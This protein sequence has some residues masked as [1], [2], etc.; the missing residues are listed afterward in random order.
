VADRVSSPP[1]PPEER[2]SSVGTEVGGAG[3]A[4]AR[5]A[6][7]LVLGQ[8]GTTTLSIVLNAA[9][10]RALGAA[11]FGM[12]FLVT[13]MAV[14]AYVFVDWGQSSYIIRDLARRP[15]R[16]GD[17]LATS[18]ALRVI[19]A[20]LVCGPV[21]VVA[22][23]LQYDARTRYLSTL[24]IA[25]MLPT[26]L[27]QC[28]TV[29]FRSQERME[30]DALV[31]VLA[32]AATLTLTLVAIAQ[33]GRLRAA[34][35]AQGL[36]GIVALA[37]AAVLLRRLGLPRLR[38]SRRTAY[39]LLV[40]GT[41]FAAIILTI[42]AQSYLDAVV[43]SKLAP[44]QVLGWYGAA[45]NI[46]NTLITPATIIASAA[47]PRLARASPSASAF[48]TEVRAALRPLLGLGA[49][50]AVGTYL[51][52]DVAV[53]VVYGAEGFGP[54][55]LLLQVF[56]PLL[57]LFMIDVLLGTAATV[58]KPGFVAFSKVIA[59]LLTTGANIVLVPVFQAR[60][61]NGAIGLLLGFAVGQAVMITAEILLL[62]AGTLDRSLVGDLG[63]ALLAGAGTVGVLLALPSQSPLLA[64]PACVLIFAGL[65]FATGLIRR[66]DLAVLAPL[67][68]R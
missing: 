1:L 32:K 26:A 21:L 67:M 28:C 4:V 38:L 13:S 52:A 37:G 56:S 41:P 45:R 27:V 64:I 42:N 2:P 11:D 24:M 23:L 33:G 68:K 48:Q 20:A 8:V 50:G 16:S 9:L 62:P 44:A 46:I 3:A 54:A 34:I 17:L 60:F 18:I 47:F 10:A 51:F 5:N 63:R 15:E 49:L 35:V 59:I 39:E 58:Y 55:T 65:A 57:L 12:L 29:I 31:S 40:G 19:G 30:L 7:H 43:L 61:D 22:W 53:R 36:G 14:F 66:A 25:A 6:F